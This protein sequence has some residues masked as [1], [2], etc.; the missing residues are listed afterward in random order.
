MIGEALAEKKAVEKDVIRLKKIIE[1][2][3]EQLAERDALIEE[4]SRK[5]LSLAEKYSL[6]TNK[7]KRL[8]KS[9]DKIKSDGHKRIKRLKRRLNISES[10]CQDYYEDN[11]QLKDAIMDM[12]IEIKLL[13][14]ILDSSTLN[15]FVKLWKSICRKLREK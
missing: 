9:I 3:N 15:Y 1:D 7:G 4:N 2:K 10:M 11:K 8:K 5:H 13:R 6:A 12:D 14:G